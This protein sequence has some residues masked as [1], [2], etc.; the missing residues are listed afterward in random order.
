MDTVGG[1][2]MGFVGFGDIAKSTAALAAPLGLNLVALRRN[3]QR[4]ARKKRVPAPTTRVRPE[5][6]LWTGRRVDLL[7][8]VRLVVCSLPLTEETRA[9]ISDEA[10]ASM[11]P[12]AVFISRTRSRHRR[13]LSTRP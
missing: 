1:S 3:R 6:N 11:K 5:S 12:S 4:P 8:A 2:T 7:R 13:R 10:F 9:S